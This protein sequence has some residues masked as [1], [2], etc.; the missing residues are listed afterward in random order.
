MNCKWNHSDCKYINEKCYLCFIEDQYYTSNIKIKEPKKAKETKRK[1]SKFEAVNSNNNNAILLGV[2]RPTPNSG[3]GYI[4]GDEQIC[5]LVNTME[6]LKEQNSVNAKGEKTFTIHK[7]WLDKLSREA[8]AENKEFW[9]LKFCFSTQDALNLIHYVII[10]SDMLMSMIKT[11]WEDRRKA[12]TYQQEID[13]YKAK[14]NRIEAE[15]LLLRA[16][17][18]E[19]KCENE[20]LKNKNMI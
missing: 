18:E 4:K 6:E 9:Y 16:Q 11:M 12:K 2:S 8:K 15:N 19:L 3:A 14:A 1:G 7:Q 17:I 20:L 10:E 5:G 13:L